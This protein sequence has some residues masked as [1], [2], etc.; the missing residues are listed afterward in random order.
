[1]KQGISQADTTV[2]NR[3]SPGSRRKILT[4]T[5]VKLALE[6]EERRKGK[7]I[8]KKILGSEKSKNKKAC[9]PGLNNF[10]CHHCDSD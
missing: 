7:N 10:I 4:D 1:M 9:T 5:P 8:R 3:S 6:E 2:L